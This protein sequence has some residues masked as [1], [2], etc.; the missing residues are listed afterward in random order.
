MSAKE[1]RNGGG[2]HVFTT[3]AV[4]CVGMCVWICARRRELTGYAGAKLVGELGDEVIVYSVLHWAQYDHRPRVVDCSG[5][6][7]Q[8]STRGEIH[9]G[10]LMDLFGQ[11]VGIHSLSCRMT[12]S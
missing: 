7:Q 6:S 8:V 9:H 1:E 4:I 12:G 2:G 10:N 3:A 5:E 11:T